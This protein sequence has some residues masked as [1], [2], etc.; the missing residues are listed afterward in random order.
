MASKVSKREQI[1]QHLQKRF[2]AA[3]AGT[4]GYSVTWNSVTRRPLSRVEVGMGDAVGLFDMRETKRQEIQHMRCDLSLVIEF[5]LFMQLGDDPGTE[6]NRMMLDIQRTIRQDIYCS[7][8]TLN[9]VESKN[10]LDI[11]GPTDAL[12]AGVVEYLIQYR[13]LVDDPS[14]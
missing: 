5:Y 4:D 2:E 14:L 11:D 7:G 3:R 8:L 13:H 6:L 10:E 12:V 1:M 9:I